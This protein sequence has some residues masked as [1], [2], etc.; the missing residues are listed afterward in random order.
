[1]AGARNVLGEQRP[2]IRDAST[3]SRG[4]A[5]AM[6]MRNAV[7]TGGG[8]NRKGGSTD[9]KASTARGDS[10]KDLK[11]KKKPKGS[12]LDGIAE[13]APSK[14]PAKASALKAITTGM[15]GVIDFI[16][17]HEVA[18]GLEEEVAPSSSA[19]PDDGS[20]GEAPEQLWARQ[21]GWPRSPTK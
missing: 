13:G 11:K 19:A 20:G 12:A 1:M 2:K 6:A 8:T 17:E 15:T 16:G 10:T 7:E 4:A 9:R 14:A 18:P 3:A 5:G 21:N